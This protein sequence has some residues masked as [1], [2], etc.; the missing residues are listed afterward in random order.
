[1]TTMD[2]IKRGEAPD[3]VRGAMTQDLIDRVV[4]FMPTAAMRLALRVQY[5]CCLRPAELFAL[6]CA[7]IKTINNVQH[8]RIELNKVLRRTNVHRALPYQERPLTDDATAVLREA[9]G[10]AAEEGRSGADPLFKV[11][12]KDYAKEFKSAVLL[13][14]IAAE[15]ADLRMVPHSVRHGAVADKAA[16]AHQE[17]RE[18]EDEE[19]REAGMSRPVA[20]NIY[21]HR[22]PAA[23]DTEEATQSVGCR[24]RGPAPGHGGGARRRGR[25]RAIG[26]GGEGSGLAVRRG[27]LSSWPPRCRDHRVGRRGARS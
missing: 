9:V 10:A 11:T 15:N 25:P 2:M 24:A 1:M 21:S 23:C 14:G 7:C 4:D 5:A 6:E 17:G 13:S 27:R 8:V 19:I 3:P 26:G 16:R 22:R 20:E 12:E 18:M